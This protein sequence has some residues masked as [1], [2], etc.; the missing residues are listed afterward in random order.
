M[1]MPAA[2]GLIGLLLSGLWE[3]WRVGTDSTGPSPGL[4]VTLCLHRD[5]LPFT[6]RLPRAILEAS[7]YPAL[8][9]ISS[10]GLGKC[11]THCTRRPEVGLEEID[12]NSGSSD[13]LCRGRPPG[14]GGAGI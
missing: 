6:L 10:L 5:L 1:E 13:S 7:S 14:Q 2:S 9:T 4:T 11:P 8:E 3:L 12:A